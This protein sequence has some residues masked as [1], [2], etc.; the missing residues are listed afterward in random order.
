[1]AT[2]LE[3]PAGLR[4]SSDVNSPT[5]PKMTALQ[6]SNYQSLS[7]QLHGGSLLITFDYLFRKCMF[8]YILDWNEE[9]SPTPASEILGSEGSSFKSPRDHHESESS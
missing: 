7:S 9:F 6:T 2:S 1:M 4:S 5:D 8:C 3:G